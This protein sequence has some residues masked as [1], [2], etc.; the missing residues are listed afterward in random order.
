MKIK[1]FYILPVFLIILSCGASIKTIV[2]SNIKTPYKNPLFILPYQRNITETF[3]NK[4]SDELKLLLSDSKQKGLV[5][6]IE[7]SKQN[8][9]A[10]NSTDDFQQKIEQ[11]VKK[12]EHDLVVFFK[13]THLMFSNNS[14]NSINYEIIG[15]DVSNNKE[16]WKANLNSNSGFGPSMFA[17]KSARFVYLNLKKDKVL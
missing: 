1:S 2:D 11:E 8:K 4:V 14:L 6:Q 7:N 3:S 5:F 15:I 9:L 10:L 16:V 12:G 13:A 17:K